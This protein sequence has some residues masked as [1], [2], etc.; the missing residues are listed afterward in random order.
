MRAKPILIMQIFLIFE[1][2]Q[3]EIGLSAYIL[4]DYVN[5][6]H[7]V[8]SCTKNDKIKGGLVV[9]LKLDRIDSFFLRLT[10]KP[11]TFMDRW[12]SKRTKSSP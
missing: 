3:E 1:E 5:I 11:I 8:I 6:Y 4:T 12:K 9:N 10:L 7:V 2:F